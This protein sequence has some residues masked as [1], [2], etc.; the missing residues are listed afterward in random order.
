MCPFQSSFRVRV[1]SNPVLDAWCG[2]RKWAMQPDFEE[3]AI[4]KEEYEEH[5][6]ERLKEHFVTNRY[7]QTPDAVVKKKTEEG[8]EVG[9]GEE[10]S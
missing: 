10:K 7:F 2:A 6:G 3:F 5:G 9:K 1:A 4:S 8:S